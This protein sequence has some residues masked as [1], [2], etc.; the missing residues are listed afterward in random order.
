MKSVRDLEPGVLPTFRLFMG[1]QFAISLL[2]VIAHRF[3]FYT[4][5]SEVIAISAL[6]GLESGLCFIYLSLPNLLRSLRSFYLPL[7]IVL[8][9]LGP[10]F[11]PWFVLNTAGA[12]SQAILEVVLWQQ[13]IV[14]FIPLI[15][16]SWQYG[17]PQVILF[18]GLTGILNIIQLTQVGL[19]GSSLGIIF[20]ELIAF[21]L[22]GHMIV[23]LV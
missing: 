2:S 11:E 19:P 22:V 1:V 23:S 5:Q 13:I 4:P 7:G 18:C 8:A 10:V 21:S 6:I 20:V 12:N 9:S 16:I 15:V 3:A 17:M 14:L